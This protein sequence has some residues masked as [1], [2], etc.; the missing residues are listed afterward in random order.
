M[1]FAPNCEIL[2][3]GCRCESGCKPGGYNRASWQPR[4]AGPATKRA[5]FLSGVRAEYRL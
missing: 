3:Q 1:P 2:L 5:G 4:P